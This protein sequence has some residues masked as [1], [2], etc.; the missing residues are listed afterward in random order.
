[1]ST[2][3][4][5]R[6][7]FSIIVAWVVLSPAIT[8]FIGIPQISIANNG[9]VIAEISI[10]HPPDLSFENGTHGKNI[11]WNATTSDPKNYT[12]T[13]DGETFLSNEWF[14]EEI[15]AS[16]DR[17]YTDNLTYSLPRTFTFV[18]TV[19]NK[20]NESAS[21]EVIVTVVPDNAAPIITQ[22]AN[23][24]YE[25]GSFGHYIKWN[26]TET[27]PDVYNV[28]RESNDPNSPSKVIEAGDWDGSNISINIDGGNASY[29]YIY[30]LFV[31]D[32]L[33]HNSTSVVNITVYEDLTNPTVTSPDDIS[34]EYGAKGNK[35]EWTVYD[36]NPKNYTI[37]ITYTYINKTY[38]YFKE[39]EVPLDNITNT[40]W[41]L[42]NPQGDQIFVYIDKLYVGN[43]TYNITLFDK[44]GHSASDAVN[45]TVY[46]DVRAPVVNATPDYS[47]EEGYTG[48][49]VNWSIDESN[50]KTFNLTRD[51]E[52]IEAGTWENMA[53]N[54][55][56]DNMTVGMHIFN[57]TLIDYFNQTTISL[58]NVTVTPDAHLPLVTDIAVIQA[59]NSPEENNLTVQ[60]YAWDL[61][62][63]S[64]VKVEWRIDE[65]NIHQKNM[66]LFT[67]GMYMADIGAFSIGSTVYYRVLVTDNSTAHNVYTSEWTPV[68]VTG[69]TEDITPPL[70]WVP[71]LILGA[72]SLL[73][74]T[75]LY[76]KTKTR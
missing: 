72:L 66:T 41:T 56:A 46:K 15:I 24:S 1:M 23:F 18:C 26:I 58:V 67:D 3:Q 19:F 40:D 29:W 11:V 39:S 50:P 8:V 42:V 61:N 64:D 35:L 16:M 4:I 53:F 6:M 65:T 9:H 25:E 45:V 49:F 30:T 36:S 52:V 73:V 48:Y 21:D 13:R 14:G 33:G 70:L 69:F 32:T 5:R 54:V 37:T 59:Y 51:G 38:G 47:Y 60:A 76:I 68:V 55:T 28:T 22:P 17:L 71:I 75:Y 62:N 74:I 20:Q 2:R 27:N 43:Y 63:I 12:I 10:N 44:F 31:N 7:A 34:Y 57:L